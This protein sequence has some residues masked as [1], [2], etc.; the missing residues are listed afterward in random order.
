MLLPLVLTL[1]CGVC[2]M[3]RVILSSV[4][5]SKVVLLFLV[6]QDGCH[7]LLEQITHTVSEG[8]VGVETDVVGELGDKV[9]A[10]GE[11]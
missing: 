5:R 1:C 2:P 4:L 8:A 10:V 7:P 11:L 3:T 9:E 6:L